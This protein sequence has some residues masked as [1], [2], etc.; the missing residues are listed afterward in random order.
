MGCAEVHGSVSDVIAHLLKVHVPDDGTCVLCPASEQGHRYPNKVNFIQHLER[1]LAAPLLPARFKH[2]CPYCWRLYVD[3][4]TWTRH[5][6]T[7]HL[8]LLQVLRVV[9][10]LSILP[11]DH[12][13]AVRN[14]V[15]DARTSALNIQAMRLGKGLRYAP[16][17]KPTSSSPEAPIALGVPQAESPSDLPMSSSKSKKS[18]PVYAAFMPQNTR[19]TVQLQNLEVVLDAEGRF[20]CP[21]KCCNTIF[22]D[23]RVAAEHMRDVYGNSCPVCPSD[24]TGTRLLNHIQRHLPP[25]IK[26]TVCDYK[27]RVKGD[28]TAHMKSKHSGK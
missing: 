23:G 26:C 11:E 8:Q 21:V 3:R 1:H 10:N 25:T 20:T 17:R 19:R 4:G 27:G 9:E 14:L 6:Q 28:I 5:L 2:E 22:S 18:G 16:Y 13:Q 12:I 7:G 24:S 15:A